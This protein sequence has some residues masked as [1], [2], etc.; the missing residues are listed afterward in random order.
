MCYFSGQYN[1][2]GIVASQLIMILVAA[3]YW[4]AS[5]EQCVVH[6]KLLP[7]VLSANCLGSVLQHIH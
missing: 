5:V 1:N 6:F 2:R 3:P 7:P 4:D